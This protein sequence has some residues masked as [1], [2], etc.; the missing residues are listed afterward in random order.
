MAIR[1]P[2]P[3]EIHRLAFECYMISHQC[4]SCV[5]SD[6]GKVKTEKLRLIG[7]AIQEFIEG[8]PKDAVSNV[9]I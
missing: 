5:S 6:P 8:Q 4:G 3:I 7:E 9:E 2:V 1:E